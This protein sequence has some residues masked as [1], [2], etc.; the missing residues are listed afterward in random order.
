MT[1]AVPWSCETE[2][3]GEARSASR[4][5]AF[6]T[7]ALRSHELDH[8]VDDIGLATS[9]LATN[10]VLHARTRFTVIVSAFEETVFLE[11]LDRS[12]VNPTVG[13]ART[14]DANGR[15]IGVV[16]AVS[17]DWG[18]IAREPD[19]KS[20]WAAFDVTPGPRG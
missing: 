15:G 18:V 3:P 16:Q 19:G 12:P 7:E 10:A 1:V 17:R 11:V 14:S 8:L 13:T 2:L 4:A 6:V 9:E 20:V 5:R